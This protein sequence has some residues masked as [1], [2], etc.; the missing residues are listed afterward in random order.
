MFQLYLIYESSPTGING[1]VHSKVKCLQ[2]VLYSG[3]MTF[4]SSFKIILLNSCLIQALW[5]NISS[6]LSYNCIHV[7]VFWCVIFFH[8]KKLSASMWSSC[9]SYFSWSS[10]AILLYTI[11]QTSLSPVCLCQY[12]KSKHLENLST[13]PHRSLC[14]EEKL[15]L[16]RKPYIN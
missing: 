1:S 14:L 6:N 8:F 12:K 5:L 13:S 9:S 4:Q 15:G 2:K 7:H 16:T 3:K 11:I 10:C